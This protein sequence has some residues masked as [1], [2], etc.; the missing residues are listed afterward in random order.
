[1]YSY[2]VEKKKKLTVHKMKF[3]YFLFLNI[4][5]YICHKFS[6]KYHFLGKRKAVLHYLKIFKNFSQITAVLKFARITF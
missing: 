2:E 6:R 4:P 1:M 3:Y 5:I